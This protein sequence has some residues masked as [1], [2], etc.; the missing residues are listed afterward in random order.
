MGMGSMRVFIGRLQIFAACCS[1]FLVC[2]CAAVGVMATSNPHAKLNDAEDLF[3]TQNRPLPAEKL[4]REAMAIYEERDD[5]HGLGNANREYGDLL[6]SSAVAKWENVYRRDGFQD[7][8][9]DF[10]TRLAKASD[11]YRRALTYY[12]R[13]EQQHREAGKYDSLTNVYYNMATSHEKLGD[14][15]KA[16]VYYDRTLEAY[17]ETIR[18]NPTAKPYAP[19]GYRSV[20]DLT[21]SEKRRAGCSE[22]YNLPIDRISEDRS[23]A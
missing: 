1:L 19:A 5:P 14:R 22:P 18:R 7:K 4:I 13:A 12:E 23:A 6:R 17:N 20:S 8:S 21:L 10:D 2:N 11:F 3:L 9:I 15:D 16:C